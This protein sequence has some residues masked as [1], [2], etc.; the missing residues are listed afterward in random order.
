MHFNVQNIFFINDKSL[1]KH[2]FESLSLAS[3]FSEDEVLMMGLLLCFG[4]PNLY[5]VDPWPKKQ[6]RAN[7]S[8]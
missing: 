7:F 8:Y 6:I 4:L 3:S 5:S 1:K 2:M